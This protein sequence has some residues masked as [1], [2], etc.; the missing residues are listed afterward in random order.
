M[1]SPVF[2]QN[3]LYCFSHKK[4]IPLQVFHKNTSAGTT[5]AVWLTELPPYILEADC[6][7]SL[8]CNCRNTRK[9]AETSFAVIQEN[10]KRT[11]KPKR[12]VSENYFDTE[13]TTARAKKQLVREMKAHYSSTNRR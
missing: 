12:S 3:L 8:Y 10:Q 11:K 1:G 5:I 6:H 9:I 2:L 4:S 13:S 7:L